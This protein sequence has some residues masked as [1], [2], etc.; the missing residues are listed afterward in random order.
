M[1]GISELASLFKERDNPIIIGIQVGEVIEPFPNIK[2][3]LG[4]KIILDKTNLLFSA[5]ILNE[6][7]KAFDVES[8][9]NITTNTDETSSAQQNSQGNKSLRIKI[10]WNNELQKGD[11]VILIAAT[12]NQ[13]FYLIDK[14]VKYD[15]A[16]DS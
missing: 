7:R 14:V 13:K 4:E 1:D 12:D 16:S 6:Y 15:A 2:I 9:T 5:H 8:I 3:A 11:E 10:K